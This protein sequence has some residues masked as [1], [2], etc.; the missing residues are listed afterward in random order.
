MV[1][2]ITPTSGPSRG[3]TPV[4]ITGTGFEAPGTTGFTGGSTVTFGAAGLATNVDEVSPTEITATVPPDS[5][6][7]SNTPVVVRVNNQFGPGSGDSDGGQ[8]LYL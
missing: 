5:G 1:G 6:I 3:R 2:S 7:A 4:T 8:Y